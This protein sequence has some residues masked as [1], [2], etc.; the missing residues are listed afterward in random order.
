VPNINTAINTTIS[1]E[2]TGL[3]QSRGYGWMLCL[4]PD[5]WSLFD[6]AGDLAIEF[7]RGTALEFFAGF[8][9][10]NQEHPDHLSLH[11]A[12]EISRYDFDRVDAL[13]PCVLSI[14]EPRLT[15]PVLNFRYFC[16]IF[17]HDYAF[18]DIR[19]VDWQALCSAAEGRVTTDT[20]NA[21]LFQIL[22]S[23]ILPLRDNHVMLSD[24][25][26]HVISD[27]TTD[28]K[29]LM[30]SELE[31]PST[32]LGE[33]KSMA[34]LSPFIRREFLAGGGTTAG[35]HCISWGIV[36][37]GVGYL[38]ILRL[39]GLADT[40][41]GRNASDLPPHRADHAALLLDDL[42]EIDRIMD[43][44]L[45]DLADAD[46]LIL[47]VRINGGGFDR[48]GMAIANRFADR[49]RAAFTKQTLH[50]DGL[51]PPQQ[52]Y[53]EPEGKIRFHGP[54]NM[55]T[56][57]RTGSAGEIFTLCM[58][59]LPQVRLI[60][61]R[62]LGILSDNLKKHLPNGWVFSI[63]N[64]FYTTPDGELFE[65]TGIPVDIEVPVFSDTDFRDTYQLAFKTALKL[66][67]EQRENAH[68]E[69]AANI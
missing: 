11:V 4:E 22:E 36:D 18:F 48:V 33:P 9:R 69:K 65:E 43:R 67:Q 10:I 24:G 13:P 31:M 21:E 51:T 49:R 7:E 35:N 52:F 27:R 16:D 59:V 64:E 62:T 44:A 61:E 60:G 25:N 14:D 8:D 20:D 40:D 15:D 2:L 17:S 45:S 66:A 46:S 47:D 63:S 39:F 30:K 26:R 19:G 56:A 12:H 53:V 28:L 6:I 3:W 5:T 34:C 41:A 68:P 37:E 58:R 38:C 50:E 55:L 42:K 57:Q 1:K 23:L 29:A 32:S 54:V